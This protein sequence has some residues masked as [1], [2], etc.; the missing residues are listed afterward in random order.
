MAAVYSFPADS[1]AHR[2]ASRVLRWRSLHPSAFYTRGFLATY[3]LV[4]MFATV[5]S[6][7]RGHA[8]EELLK[9]IRDVHADGAAPELRMLLGVS[10]ATV[11]ASITF[12]FA[13]RWLP[14]RRLPNPPDETRS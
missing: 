9:L 14:V 5:R 10:S 1:P 6:G 4:T 2:S 13:L 3:Q 7:G 11:A 8:A 12:V